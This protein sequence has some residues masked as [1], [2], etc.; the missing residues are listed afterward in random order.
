MIIIMWMSWIISHII[1]NIFSY[2]LF[3]VPMSEPDCKISA[4]FLR[5][6]KT[7]PSLSFGARTPQ[8]LSKYL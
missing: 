3:I 5:P 4:F 6:A 2:L 7:K 1:I 8:V